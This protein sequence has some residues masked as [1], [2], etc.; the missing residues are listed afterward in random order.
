M[1]EMSRDAALRAL[2]DPATPAGTLMA[3]VSAHPDL[4]RRASLHANAYPALVEWV[5]RYAP[6][7]AQQ[8]APDAA[9]GDAPVERPA[10]AATP[11]PAPHDVPPAEQEAPPTPA[12]YGIPP[13]D[14][15]A[16]APPAPLPLGVPDAPHP[17]GWPTDAGDAPEPRPRRRGMLVGAVIAIAVLVGGGLVGGTIAWV[18]AHEAPP[19]ATDDDGS[20]AEQ[21]ATGDEGAADE[22]ADAQDGTGDDGSSAS[23]A[24]DQH[25]SPDDHEDEFRDAAQ[26][27]GFPVELQGEWCPAEPNES[28]AG[29][30]S[31]DDW[32]EEYP[33]GFLA[34]T[35]EDTGAYYGVGGETLFTLCISHNTGDSCVMAESMSLT[36]YPAGVDSRVCD[37]A[38]ADGYSDCV[39]GYEP[40]TSRDRLLGELNHQQDSAYHEG[41]LMYRE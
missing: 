32:L 9:P 30:F 6:A 31:V 16:T 3:I 36:F 27:N 8:A 5:R 7:D 12:P 14:P 40:D 29:C 33:D 17:A 28:D 11:E 2:A 20:D 22:G 23:P 25:A 1:T 18:K 38:L 41:T 13:A 39:P 10:A 26:R 34:D 4:G 35:S 19:A 24:P 21:G 37:Q 15:G